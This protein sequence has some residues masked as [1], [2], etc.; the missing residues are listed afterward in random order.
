MSLHMRSA[1]DPPRASRSPQC[2]RFVAPPRCRADLLSPRSLPVHLAGGRRRKECHLGA[3]CNGAAPSM[4]IEE[5]KLHHVVEELLVNAPQ[6]KQRAQRGTSGRKRAPSEMHHLS[7][8]EQRG[9]N[10]EAQKVAQVSVETLSQNDLWIHVR[11]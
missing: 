2:P 7:A 11:C 1:S 3:G 10:M 4:R 9:N 6:R 8:N 5:R